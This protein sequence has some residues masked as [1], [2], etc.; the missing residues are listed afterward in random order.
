M[1]L[2]LF[3]ELEDEKQI[4][5]KLAVQLEKEINTKIGQ[6]VQSSTNDFER[7]FKERDFK[8]QKEPRCVTAK[9][10]SAKVSLQSQPEHGYMGYYFIFDLT[11]GPDKYGVSLN[12]K[13][14][15]HVPSSHISSDTKGD[16]ISN[17]IQL[18]KES[19]RRA[20]DRIK[21][22]PSEEWYL[23]L[24]KQNKRLYKFNTMYELLTFITTTEQKL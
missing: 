10:G 18:L 3:K 17:Q 7:F 13:I 11:L 20:E 8:V 23:E 9:Y 2:D 21:N 1:N 5:K 22:F 15:N 4:N 16:K 19:N 12:P 6:L 14:D 24:L